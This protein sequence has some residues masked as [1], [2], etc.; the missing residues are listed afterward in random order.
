MLGKVWGWLTGE[1]KQTTELQQ[2]A[3][4][5]LLRAEHVRLRALQ[6]YYDV[7]TIRKSKR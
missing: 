4:K 5:V 7:M 2:E 6:Q 3:A 1:S